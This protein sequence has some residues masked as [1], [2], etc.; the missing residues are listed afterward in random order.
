MLWSTA[1]STNLTGPGRVTFAVLIASF[2]I[3]AVLLS[4]FVSNTT[5]AKLLIPMTLALPQEELIIPCSLAAAF[6]SSLAVALP[7]S[8][9]PML[10]AYGTG[11]VRPREL[12]HVGLVLGVVG[13]L[14]TVLCIHL[15]T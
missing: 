2:C 12:L 1:G 9:P 13:T 7:V 5:T 3:L 11:I 10:L 4:T 6:G 15:L 8:T 14:L